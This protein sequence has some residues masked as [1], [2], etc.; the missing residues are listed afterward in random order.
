G[1]ATALYNNS[2]TLP[3]GVNVNDLIKAGNITFDSVTSD[4]GT[5]VLHW[6]YDP[7]GANLDFLKAGDTLKLIYTAQVSDGHGSTGNQ[8]LVITL[9]G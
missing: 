7:H 9:V 1:K 8:Q 6:S 5:D 3:N 4:G 2:S